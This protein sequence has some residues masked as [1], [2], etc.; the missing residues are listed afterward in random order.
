MICIG[1]TFYLYPDEVKRLNAGLTSNKT[2]TL[3]LEDGQAIVFVE[4]P[5]TNQQPQAEH[6]AISEK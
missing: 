3:T 5:Y 1:N 4:R 6:K 2:A